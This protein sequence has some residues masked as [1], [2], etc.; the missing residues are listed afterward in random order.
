MLKRATLSSPTSTCPLTIHQH[1]GT[2]RT[3]HMVE[4]HNNVKDLDRICNNIMPHM[5]S[6]NGKQDREQMIRGR[7]DLIHLKTIC[8]LS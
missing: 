4:E 6:K 8:L 3:S 2:M 1:S 7:G 5:G